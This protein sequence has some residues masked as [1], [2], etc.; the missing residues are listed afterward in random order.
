MVNVDLT[1]IYYVFGNLGAAQQT[2]NTT[3]IAANTSENIWLFI[4]LANIDQH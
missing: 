2:V 4:H 3:D 1:R